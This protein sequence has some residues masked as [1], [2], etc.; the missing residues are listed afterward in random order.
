MQ[1]SVKL[2]SNLIQTRYAQKQIKLVITDVDGTLASFWDYF[3]PAI[4]EF[5]REISIKTEIPVHQLAEDIGRVIARRGTHEYP[6]MLEETSFAWKYFQDE[7]ARFT[8]L[9]VMPFWHTLERNRNKYLRPYPEV[10]NTLVELKRRGLTIVALTD[11]PDY[12]ARKKHQQIF[13]GLIDALYAPEL[14]EPQ[15]TDIWKPISVEYGLARVQE[16]R[17]STKNL[18]TQFNTLPAGFA[19]PNPAGIDKILSDFNLYPQEAILIGNNLAKDGAA[20]ARRGV[21]FV[22]AQYGN[23]LPAEYEELVHHALKPE[24]NAPVEFPLPM[25]LVAATAA[26]YDEILKHIQ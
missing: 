13:D 22:W 1:E 5:L 19:K 9:F 25:S 23:N 2:T 26:R 17:E 7:P 20:A 3:V 15:T 14:V 12:I 21:K 8:E 10:I 18:K 24:G 16:M 6:W 11:A 4:R